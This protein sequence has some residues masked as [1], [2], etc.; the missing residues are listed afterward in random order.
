[1]QES[2]MSGSNCLLGWLQEVSE[3]AESLRSRIEDG[4]VGNYPENIVPKLKALYA[5]L[6]EY[7]ADCMIG[8]DRMRDPGPSQEQRL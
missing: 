6:H 2:A 8:H 5:D 4:E 7:E 3:K 1:H